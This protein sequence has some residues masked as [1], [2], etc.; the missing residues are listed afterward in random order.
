VARA[1]GISLPAGLPERHLALADTLEPG[2]YSSLYDDLTHERAMELEAL[3]GEVIRRA[4]RARVAVPM[5]RALYAVLQPWER[6]NRT[7][8]NLTMPSTGPS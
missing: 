7:R 1:E 3:L 6:R 2:G 8:S 4:N 5:S